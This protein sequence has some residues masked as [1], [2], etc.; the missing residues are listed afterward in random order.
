LTVR[1]SLDG[2]TIFVGTGGARDDTA[3]RSDVAARAGESHASTERRQSVV[4]VHGA[5][6]DH[7]VWVMPARHFARH[8]FH[9]LAPDLPGHGRSDGPALESI[10][11]LADWLARVLDATGVEAAAVV[12]HSMG[13]LI[14]QSLAIRHPTRVRALALL[15]TSVPMPVTERLLA[16]AARNDHAATDMANGWSHSARARLGGSP[17]PGFWMLGIGARLIERTPPG[18]HHADLAA[19]NAYHGDPSAIAAPTLVIV[20]EQD[21]MTPARAGREV[22]GKIADAR[23]VTLPGAGHAMLAERPNEVLDALITIV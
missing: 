17:N 8:G 7:T 19:C 22:A 13:A 11:A 23:V 14:A 21:Q 4:F 10:D 12:G 18:V 6:H 5:A 3:G 16:A 1:I 2:R 9:V 20:G 15:G